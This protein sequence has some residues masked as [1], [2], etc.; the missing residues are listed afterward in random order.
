MLVLELTSGWRGYRAGARFPMEV[1]G[2][3][4]ADV[5]L[6]RNLARLLPDDDG[7]TERAVDPPHDSHRDTAD[8]GAGNDQRSESPASHRRKRRQ[9]RR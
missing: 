2:S 7:A 4:V 5:L 3:G 9:P 6:R 1:I 8:S